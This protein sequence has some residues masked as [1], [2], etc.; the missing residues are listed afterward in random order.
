MRVMVGKLPACVAVV[1]AYAASLAVAS[2]LA[3][4]ALSPAP[5][6]GGGRFLPHENSLP[7]HGLSLGSNV[8]NVGLLVGTILSAQ[9][10]A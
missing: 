7:S 9:A 3:Y 6:G 4:K 10:F 5:V 2:N 8:V 1:I